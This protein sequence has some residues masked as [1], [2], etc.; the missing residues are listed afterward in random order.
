MRKTRVE[1]AV[2]QTLCHDMTAILEDGFKGVK[3]RRGHVIT[4]GD[5]PE[6]KK[7][8][9]DHIFVW[10]PEADEVHEEDAAVALCEAM[11]AESLVRSAPAEGKVTVTAGEDGLFCIDSSA[12]RAINTVP[13]YTVATVPNYYAVKA[14]DRLAGARIVP[15]VTRRENMDKAVSIA[16]ENYPV[17]SVRPFRRLKAAEIIT[18]SE[19]YYGRIKDAF[20]PILDAKLNRY[21]AEKLG[22]TKCPDDAEMIVAA[23][24]S[25]VAQGAELIL[26]TGG[27][28]VDPDDVTPT[29]IRETGARVVVNGVPMQPGNMLNIAYLGNTVLVGVPGASMHSPITSLEVFLPRIFAGVEICEEEI[30]GYGEGGLCLRCPVCTYPKCGFGRCKGI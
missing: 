8:G 24:E 12:L 29:A 22:C 4:E 1:D 25:Y 16:K 27:M 13:D 28:S 20:E 5:I 11:C 2:G 9:K 6:L 26:L 17:L 14:G 3:F 15:L 7:I 18:G 21:G 19:I 23:I 30:A 10:E